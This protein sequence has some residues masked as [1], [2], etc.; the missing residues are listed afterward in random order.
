[1]RKDAIKPKSFSMYPKQKNKNAGTRNVDKKEDAIIASAL[2]KI[3][4]KKGRLTIPPEV[5][6]QASGLL[7]PRPA[8]LALLQTEI[9]PAPVKRAMAQQIFDV[10][11]R[12]FEKFDL[13]WEA[14]RNMLTSEPEE[15]RDQ[16]RDGSPDNTTTK[17]KKDQCTW[18]MVEQE[19]LRG[20]EMA[21]KLG[22][23]DG[24]AGEFTAEAD[25]LGKHS[26]LWWFL[27]L[28]Y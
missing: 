14:T 4:F 2:S 3:V 23:L 13:V 28:T 6:L 5:M 19:R 17:K 12:F 1:M 27:G 7:P 24:L 25:A 9:Y 20:L 16:S 26:D 8:E 11:F 21:S 10:G 18:D 22:A 15:A